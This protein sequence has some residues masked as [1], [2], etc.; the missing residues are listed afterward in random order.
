[1]N[2]NLQLTSRSSEKCFPMQFFNLNCIINSIISW[3]HIHIL[4][5][6]LFRHLVSKSSAFYATWR[7]IVMWDLRLSWRCSWGFGHSGLWYCVTEQVDTDI[8]KAPWSVETWGTTH[9]ATWCHLTQVYLRVQESP[10][11][12]PV[13]RWMKPDHIFAPSF[14]KV[15]LL[16]QI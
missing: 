3:W 6:P 2:I 14:I 15:H 11:L 13:L 8:L 10:S 16:M 7:F 4:E 5:N 12:D 9:P 1:M